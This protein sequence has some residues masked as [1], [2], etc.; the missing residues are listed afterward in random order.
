MFWET[1]VAGG[2]VL[3]CL[4]GAALGVGLSQ[5]PIHTTGREGLGFAFP[6]P[7]PV[8]VVKACHVSPN[9]EATLR[10]GRVTPLTFNE[11]NCI[12]KHSGR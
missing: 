1:V 2:V 6:S 4:V 7:I 8:S 5:S 12:V 11:L 9:F 10:V 3:V